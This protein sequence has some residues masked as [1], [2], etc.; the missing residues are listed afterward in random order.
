VSRPRT[1]G[2][3]DDRA[4]DRLCAMAAARIGAAYGIGADAV[5]RSCSTR[6]DG[7][8]FVTEAVR[9]QCPEKYR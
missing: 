9:T 3:V 5:A 8:G 2:R 4:M 7:E 6:G 1:S